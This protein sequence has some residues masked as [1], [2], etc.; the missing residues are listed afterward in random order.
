MAMGRRLKDL[1][2]TLLIL[3]LASAYIRGGFE[4]PLIG[5]AAPSFPVSLLLIVMWFGGQLAI[6]HWNREL[7]A[8]TGSWLRGH[9]PE[10]LIALLF[11]VGLILRLWGIGFGKPLILHPDEHQVVGVAVT[12]LKS[13]WIAPP[14]PYHYPTVFHYLLL[15]GFA[16]LYVKGKSTGMWRSLDDIH[17][18]TFEFYE[19]ARAHSAVLGA[20]TI[21]LTFVLATRLWPGRRGRWTGVIAATYITFAF[22][23][24]KESH[25]GVTD[26]ALT[27]F[28][29]VAFIAIVSAW[30][31]GTV[32]SFALAGFAAGIAC[33][34]KYSALPIVAVLIAAHFLQRNGRWTAWPRLAAGLAAVPVGF[35]TGYPYA[36]LN[37]PPFLE[38][39]GW[40][41]GHSGMGTFDPRYRFHVIVKYAMESGL[42][43]L[44]TLTL[45][46]AGVFAI[47]RR[48]VEEALEIV[49]VVVA[50]SLL[51][52]TAFPFY[53][54][55]LV[56]LMPA[57]AILVGSFIVAGWEQ[58]ARAAGPGRRAMA[59][60]AAVALVLAIMWPQ[61]RESVEYVQYITSTDTRVGAYEY[62]VANI[63]AGS[64][65]ATEEPYLRLPPDFTLIQWT[66][67]HEIDLDEISAS[68]V[69]VLVLSG[70]RD[71][72]DGSEE[73]RTRRE[74]RR[75]FPMQAVFTHGVH[76]LVGPTIAIHVRPAR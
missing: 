9:L 10:V 69:D 33:A 59:P 8:R 76:G 64:T 2:S 21:V 3:N 25:H 31:R 29:V 48:R 13:G 14:T 26:A 74:L 12:M 43:W 36:F 6:R 49:F 15:P 18:E 68:G 61:A 72:N 66:R 39:L 46:A 73:D 50:L 5:V 57:T 42:G 62:I 70:D 35:F 34:T 45:A 75:R 47:Y 53:P 63:P 27:F 23:H 65:V 17:W 51:A 19:L 55:Y 40:M 11:V 1:V 22:N 56:P 67:T 52:N 37:W 7:P 32:A 71:I 24:V 28:V 58:L 60:L 16:L 41:S 44:F 20:L 4:I 54:R 30:R 38:H